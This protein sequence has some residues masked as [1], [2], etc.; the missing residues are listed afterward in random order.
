MSPAITKTPL[1]L[2]KI[3]PK[4]QVTIP[5]TVRAQMRLDVGDL[6]GVEVHK[7]IIIIKPQKVVDKSSKKD[8]DDAIAEGLKDI[9]AGREFGPFASVKEFKTALKNR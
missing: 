8:I 4:Y 9:A 3:K 7:N 6:V 5:Y 2:T 1:S